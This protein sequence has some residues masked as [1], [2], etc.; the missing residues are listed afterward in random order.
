MY[1]RISERLVSM[2][3]F[4]WRMLRHA[5]YVLAI[6][7]L[8]LLAGTAGFILIEGHPFADAIIHSAHILSGLGL[9]EMPATYAGRIFVAL[10]GLYSSLVFLAAFSVLSAPIIHRILHKLHLD[11]E[12]VG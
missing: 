2:E 11:D 5:G 9:V 1:E 3:H 6:F 8:S 7:A 12:K 4:V 10:F